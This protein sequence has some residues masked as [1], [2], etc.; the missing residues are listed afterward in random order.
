[1]LAT[2]DNFSEHAASIRD[3]LNQLN[4]KKSGADS[5]DYF[6]LQKDAFAL[7]KSIDASGGNGGEN[8]RIADELLQIGESCGVIARGLPRTPLASPNPIGGGGRYTP[9]DGP[10]MTGGGTRAIPTSQFTKSAGL[11]NGGFDSFGEFLKAI[12]EQAGGVRFDD[13]LSAMAVGQNKSS[14]SSGGFLVPE[15]Y[16]RELVTSA[17]QAQPWLEQR[18]SFIVESGN[19]MVR[20]MLRDRDKSGKDTAGV[21]LARMAEAGQIPLSTAIFGSRR[22]QLAKAAA[23]VRVSNELL[24]DSA[25]GVDE[26]ATALVGQAV[27]LRQALD[28]FSGTGVGEPTGF[29]KSGALYTVAKETGQ[30][31][32][33]IVFKNVIGMMARLSPAVFARSYWLAHPGTIEQLSLLTIAAGTAGQPVWVFNAAA[34]PQ[35]TL[36]GRPIHFTEAASLLGDKGD[37]SLIDPQSYLYGQ[38][39]VRIDVSREFRFDYDETEFRIVLRDAGGPLYDTTQKDVQGYEHSEFVTLA[40]RA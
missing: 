12:R 10:A 22:D 7:A 13:R 40:A 17:M 1:M 30:V 15:S 18:R 24:G 39:R 6:I 29:L 8:G 36:M 28:M 32:D 37:I 38:M 34:A 23:R 14:D 31:A 21:A 19:D 5:H 4:G 35:Q 20:P 16:Q 3:R 33:T 9:D 2:I 27:A 25:V 11:D 26:V